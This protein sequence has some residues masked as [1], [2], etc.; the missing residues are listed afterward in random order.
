MPGADGKIFLSYRREDRHIAG[1]MA[2]GLINRFGADHVFLDVDTLEPGTDFVQGIT[3]AVGR[4][5]VLVAVL[6]P[7]WLTS[8]DR[9]GRRKLD[10]PEDFVVLEIRTALDR[11]VRV[12][13]VLV[14]TATMPTPDELPHSLRDLSRRQAVAVEHSTFHSDF[15]RMV[16]TIEKVLREADGGPAAAGR[17]VAASR[18]RTGPP[19]ADVRIP[20]RTAP[21]AT[22]RPRPHRPGPVDAP[23]TQLTP[24]RPA[25]PRPDTG[26]S[27]AGRST[28]ALHLRT[29]RRI[30]LWGLVFV[31]A[32]LSSTGVV[33]M[34]RSPDGPTLVTGLIANAFLLGTLGGAIALLR[35]EVR[36]QR[37]QLDG[38]GLDPVRR[39]A[40]QR[41]L[42]RGRLRGLSAACAALCLLFAVIMFQADPPR[43]VRSPQVPATTA[44]TG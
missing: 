14:D 20:S 37:A 13:P 40:A 41:P 22:E 26:A 16:A 28:A 18:Q 10:D 42:T 43:S 19:P 27:R 36:L 33:F 39:S 9:S 12:I 32:A 3:E 1:R 38:T 34:V 29:A 31:L 5:A 7:G 25:A 2:D 35:R 15:H 24:V 21:S 30:G 23:T 17:P 6:G 8:T 11:D 4:C 44:T